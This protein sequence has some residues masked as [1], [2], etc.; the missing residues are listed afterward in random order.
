MRSSISRKKKTLQGQLL[1]CFPDVPR[2]PRSYGGKE[3]RQTGAVVSTQTLVPQNQS[4]PISSS[5]LQP[6]IDF[7]QTKRIP[8]GKRVAS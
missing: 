7:K 6:R 3:R 8:L 2:S 5:H 4:P 1:Q